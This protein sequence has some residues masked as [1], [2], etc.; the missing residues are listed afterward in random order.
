M[1]GHPI[2]VREIMRHKMGLPMHVL[3][4]DRSLTARRITPYDE[5]ASDRSF[6]RGTTKLGRAFAPTIGVE[7]MDKRRGTIGLV[8]A[9]SLALCACDATDDHVEFEDGDIELRDGTLAGGDDGGDGGQG[10]IARPGRP[11]GGGNWGYNGL[12]NINISGVDTNHG[13]SSEQGMAPSGDLLLVEDLRGTAEYIVECA[14]PA[15]EQVVKQVGDET[16][17]FEG[18]VG[19]APEWKDGA[20]D[21]DCQEWVTACLLARTNTEGQEI[22]IWLSGDHPGLGLGRSPDFPLHEAAFYGNIFQDPD[23]QFVCRGGL[24]GLI[25]AHLNGRTCSG[26]SPE[27]CGFSLEGNCY[28][29]DRCDIVGSYPYY[30][31]TNCAAGDPVDDIRYNTISAFAYIPEQWQQ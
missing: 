14:L 15:G 20:C 23:A 17:V 6:S 21:T 2:G 1:A 30:F 10:T 28:F 19:L 22:D 24:L 12:H 11:S 31:T 29:N 8:G 4:Q 25:G 18:Q 27:D 16:L 13:L 3:S 5:H 26:Q 7:T 9:L